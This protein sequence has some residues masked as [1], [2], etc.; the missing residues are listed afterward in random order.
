MGYLVPL[1]C[2]YK[3]LVLFCLNN[4]LIK[5][6]FNSKIKN[7]LESRSKFNSNYTKLSLSNSL[8]LNN[9]LF[10]PELSAYLLGHNKDK[11]VFKD[12]QGIYLIAFSILN[13]EEKS[14]IYN[15]I[16]YN[17]LL[18]LSIIVY[19]LTRNYFIT[20]DNHE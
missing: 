13:K 15:Y 7:P 10:T 8:D 19:F 1:Y 14:L 5:N 4:Y 3:K 18:Y 12:K 20:N 6:M 16:Y 2:K 11:K 17:D 9:C